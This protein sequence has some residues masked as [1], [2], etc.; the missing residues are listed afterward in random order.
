MWET[1]RKKSRGYKA[2]NWNKIISEI[3]TEMGNSDFF[4]NLKNNLC[5][6][7]GP[8][9]LVC[10]GIGSLCNSRSARHQMALIDCLLKFYENLN[11]EIIF[12]PA[13]TDEGRVIKIFYPA[14]QNN[15]CMASFIS[16]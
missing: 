11:F 7:D 5:L 1:R 13:F 10:L 4:E 9:S 2:P 3:G 14:P 15:F 16:F 12:D 8:V 6:P